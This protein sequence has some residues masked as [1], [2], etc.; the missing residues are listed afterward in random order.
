MR[1]PLLHRLHLPRVRQVALNHNAGGYCTLHWRA[2][3]LRK[4]KLG[5]FMAVLIALASLCAPLWRVPSSHESDLALGMTVPE[6]HARFG[7]PYSRTFVGWDASFRLGPSSRFAPIDSRWLVV[8]I[9]D[10]V[11]TAARVIVD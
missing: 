5:V 9:Q 4:W 2:L 3:G 6:L 8:R 7:T 10:G 11:V 1:V